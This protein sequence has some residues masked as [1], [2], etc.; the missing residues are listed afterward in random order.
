MCVFCVYIDGYRHRV[1]LGYV[2]EQVV[3]VLVLFSGIVECN[4]GVAEEDEVE[5]ILAQEPSADQEV[6]RDVILP[7]QSPGE[8][9]FNEFFNPDKAPCLASI[10]ED[11]LGEGSVSASHFSRWFS[12]PS[13]SGSVSS[14]LGSTSHEKLERLAGL[15]QAVLSPGQNSGNYFP[16][17]SVDRAENRVDILEMLQKG[18]VD[19]KPLLSSLSANKE[20]LKKSSHSGAVLSVEEVEAGLQSLKVDQQMKNSTSFMGEHLEEILSAVTSNQQLKRDGNMTA[21]NKLV[22]TMKASGTL[23]T[24]PKV[25]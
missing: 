9:D 14:S 16:I 13:R 3:S 15:E 18:K 22:N 5:V 24:Q 7:E 2:P 25:S 6:P 8:F 10:I 17:P 1:R 20:K 11:V 19:L 4:G 12:N 23:P 21:F